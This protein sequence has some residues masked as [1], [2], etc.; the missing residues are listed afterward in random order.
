LFTLESYRFAYLIPLA[1]PFKLAYPSFLY[2]DPFLQHIARSMYILSLIF[3]FALYFQFFF[4][5]CKENKTKYI[6]HMNYQKWEALIENF[7]F[8]RH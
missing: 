2:S 8:K 7:D 4:L 6:R 5:R 3:F 1:F